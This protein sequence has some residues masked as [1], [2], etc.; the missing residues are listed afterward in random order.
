STYIYIYQYA[1]QKNK[2]LETLRPD[3]LTE[4][5]KK[6]CEDQTRPTDLQGQQERCQTHRRD[7]PHGSLP[8]TGVWTCRGIKTNR[9]RRTISTRSL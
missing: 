8:S 2:S 7:G 4:L 9:I 3:T 6:P 5:P 1:Q